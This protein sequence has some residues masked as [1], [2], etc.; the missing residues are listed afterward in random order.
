MSLA[1]GPKVLAER[2]WSVCHDANVSANAQRTFAV[3][4]MNYINYYL[5]CFWFRIVDFVKNKQKNILKN[6]EINQQ[7]HITT[8]VT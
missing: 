5:M 7:N 1:A 3:N 8:Y 6:P 2:L 4:I